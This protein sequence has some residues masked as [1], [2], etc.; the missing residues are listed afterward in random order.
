MPAKKKMDV[1]ARVRKILTAANQQI[2]TRLNL[3]SYLG[4]SHM[5]KRDIYETLGYDKEIEIERYFST[6]YRQDIAYRIVNAYPDAI[7]TKHPM[8]REGEEREE[9]KM[10]AFEEA[11]SELEKRTRLFHYLNRVDKLSALGH[12]AVLLIG[13]RDGME[14]TEPMG[15]L[16]SP[17]DIVY[18]MAF[19]EKN[20]QIQAFDEDPMSERYGLPELYNLQTGGYAA[21]QNSSHMPS[22]GLHV[23]HS[24]VIHVAE[25]RLENDVFGTP[26]LKPVFNRLQDLEKVSGGSAE[27]FWLNGRGGL[28]L[29]LDKDAQMGL[30]DGKTLTEQVETYMNN[31]SRFLKTQGMDVK[32]IEMQIH[33]P[34][35]HVEILLDQIAG[36]VGIPKRILVGSERGELASSQDENNWWSRV[37]ERR[38][39]FCEPLMLRELVDRLI[40]VNAL[41]MPAE[42]YEIDWPELYA[43]P[44]SE[45]AERAL[46]ISQALKAYAETMG[47][48][49][50]I[51]PKQFV[52]EVVGLEYREEDIEAWLMDE[53]RQMEQDQLKDDQ[54]L[55]VMDEGGESGGSGSDS[56]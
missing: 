40:M 49:L 41:P 7:W 15:R 22:H 2:I 47:T 9:D 20:A 34:D 8:V 21:S 45:R 55:P 27:I 12:Y 10:T 36:G 26:R 28:N 3:G 44:E 29:N 32:P 46:K 1:N 17:E 11:F 23:H 52:E 31:M 39:N 6:Y 56:A 5:G 4:K 51:P 37:E 54:T 19:H 14:L 53:R 30:E 42:D 18:L 43:A 35:K 33:E 50:V 25:G 13:A 24:R 16:S 38:D 48:D